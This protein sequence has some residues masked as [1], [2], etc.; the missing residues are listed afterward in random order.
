MEHRKIKHMEFVQGVINRLAQSS[1]LLKGWSVVLV[2]ALS[3]LAAENSNRSFIFLAYIPVIVFWGLDG[4]FLRQEKMFRA[5]YDRVRKMEDDAIDFSMSTKS[6]DREVPALA[7]VIFS[8]TL[9]AFHG[10]LLFAVVVV[11]LALL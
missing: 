10:G 5:L 4:Y 2:A 1:F 3:A 11:M 6:V 8:A 9:V 7:R